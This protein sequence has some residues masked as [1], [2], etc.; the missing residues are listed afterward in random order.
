M[1]RRLHAI[2]LTGLIVWL[3]LGLILGHGA[4]DP[5]WRRQVPVIG[6]W[7][8]AAV[9]LM[10]A[11]RRIPAAARWSWLAHPLL[12]APMIF[13]AMDLAR[14]H[15][16]A[17]PTALAAFTTSIYCVAVCVAAL[18]LRQ[19]AIL[20]V[21]LVSIPF[22]VALLLRAGV[23]TPGW[24]VSS[25][26]CIALVAAACIALLHR[27]TSL[28]RSVAREQQVRLRLRRYLPATAVERVAEA[29]AERSSGEE[30]ELTLLMSDIRDF[31]AL[32]E[33]LPGPRVVDLL[34]EYF[35][36]MTDVLFRHG[37]TLD[38]FIGDGMLAY[39]GA[40]LPRADHAAAA[41][42]CGVEM[43]EA[44]A[45]L[46]RTRESRGEPPLRIGIGVHTGKVIF[47][48][49]GA[50]QRREYAVIGDPVNTV[51]R[52]EALTKEHGVPLLVSGAAREQAGG[53]WTWSA[54]APL[55]VKGKAEPV[56]TWVPSRPA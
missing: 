52:I 45:V 46:N 44:L 49:I 12:D 37:G 30:R 6:V 33:S 25:P 18:T 11:A 54:C 20:C 22:Q 3:G 38:K 4:G 43:L 56:A 42:A 21:A 5:E 24:Y 7:A 10:A 55:P 53:A 48:D 27:V 13:L 40:P 16:L 50:E 2:R 51:S 47:G 39:F 34:N 36:A 26:I 35:A 14:E 28:A 17:S 32:T 23:A 41:V 31:T 19:V 9:G 8:A 1:D 29:H 15:T